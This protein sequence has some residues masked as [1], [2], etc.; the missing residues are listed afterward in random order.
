MIVVNNNIVTIFIFH[1][2]GITYW[3]LSVYK[4]RY[5]VFGTIKRKKHILN[6]WNQGSG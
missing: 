6:K 4:K 2:A 5:Q 1:F 3:A